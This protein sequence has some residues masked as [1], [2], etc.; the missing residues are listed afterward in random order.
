VFGLYPASEDAGYTRFKW[1]LEAALVS[2]YAFGVAGAACFFCVIRH[3]H[4]TRCQLCETGVE[5]G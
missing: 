5:D 3:G 4:G 2:R 1:K